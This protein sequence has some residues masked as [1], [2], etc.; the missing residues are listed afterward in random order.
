MR[1][2]GV[3]EMQFNKLEAPLES[4]EVDAMSSRD[5]AIVK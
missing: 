1:E 2:I 4:L 5:L 3:E